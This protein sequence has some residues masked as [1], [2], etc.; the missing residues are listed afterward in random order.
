LPDKRESK[1]PGTPYRAN[2]ATGNSLK[3]LR[4]ELLVFNFG[5]SGD[6][7][8]LLSSVFIRGKVLLFSVQ[9]SVIRVH[10]W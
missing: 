10:P 9:I 6:F 8:N 3:E 7:G 4:P 5:N 1:H 2:A